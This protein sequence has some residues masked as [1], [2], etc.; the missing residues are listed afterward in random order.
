MEVRV[1][2]RDAQGNAVGNL[3]KDDFQLTDNGKPQGNLEVLGMEQV[4]KPIPGSKAGSSG[5]GN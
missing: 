3:K 5:A 2:V 1:V 4:Q